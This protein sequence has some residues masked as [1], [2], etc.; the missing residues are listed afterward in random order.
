MFFPPFEYCD[1]IILC[2]AEQQLHI[3]IIIFY[4][5][6]C[7]AKQT[8]QTKQ[9]KQAEQAKQATQA[10]QG[11]HPPTL[12][13]H[14]TH[15]YGRPNAHLQQPPLLLR[16]AEVQEQREA[17]GDK[18]RAAVPRPLRELLHPLAQTA[19]R[20]KA[21]IASELVCVKG[22]KKEI[23]IHTSEITI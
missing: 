15:A 20:G 8:K 23:L 22:V 10:K 11:K 16:L 7:Q 1:G 18:L 3:L 13:T 2:K 6:Y 14:T 4:V 17:V 12:S 21:S 19:L 5:E 9:A